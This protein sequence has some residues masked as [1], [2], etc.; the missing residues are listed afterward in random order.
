MLLSHGDESPRCSVQVLGLEIAAFSWKMQRKH[1]QRCLHSVLMR[2]SQFIQTWHEFT[3]SVSLPFYTWKKYRAH[4]LNGKVACEQLRSSFFMLRLKMILRTWLHH[5]RHENSL[6]KRMQLQHDRKQ[7]SFLSI[8][9]NCWRGWSTTCFSTRRDLLH[10]MLKK[11]RV[12]QLLQYFIVWNLFSH[13]RSHI[14]KQRTTS[15]VRARL[16]SGCRD[17]LPRH[18]ALDMIPSPPHIHKLEAFYKRSQ[19]E[20][21]RA[22]NA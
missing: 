14:M 11:Y 12:Y 16:R 5:Y 6:R 15:V 20:T 18:K 9:L 1:R 17:D 3:A 13:C 22:Q 8:I 2:W 19:L 10:T 21:K 7:R 4:R